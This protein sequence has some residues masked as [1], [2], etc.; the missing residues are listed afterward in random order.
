[1]NV[2]KVWGIVKTFLPTKRISAWILGVIAA[3]VALVMGVSGGDLK[4]Q[5][6]ENE[7]VELPKVS[8]E[9]PAEKPKAE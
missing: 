8:V 3:G 5:F 2:L 7:P 4:E 9:A 6:C 1:M